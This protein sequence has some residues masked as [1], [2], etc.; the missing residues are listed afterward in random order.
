MTDMTAEQA[1]L[2]ARHKFD[3][4]GASFEYEV[5][6]QALTAPRVPEGFVRAGDYMDAV[7]RMEMI[8]GASQHCDCHAFEIANDYLHET[9]GGQIPLTAASAPAD[10]LAAIRERI[11]EWLCEDCNT[12]HTPP[13]GFDLTCK[14]PGCVGLLKPSTLAE[15]KLRE[16]VKVLEEALAD[17]ASYTR[18]SDY[19]WDMGFIKHVD[20]LLAARLRGGSDEN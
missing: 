8:R 14:T 18:H 20:R 7:D 1:L 9:H 5:M 4:C 19:D 13:S 10:E 12:V 11:P 15:R 2:Q 3:L 6:R 16:Q 17:A